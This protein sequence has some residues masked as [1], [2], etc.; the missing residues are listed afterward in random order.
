M[1]DCI[2]HHKNTLFLYEELVNI[3]GSTSRISETK[4]CANILF[5]NFPKGWV[6]ET[7]LAR[8]TEKFCLWSQLDFRVADDPSFSSSDF[9]QSKLLHIFTLSI[10]I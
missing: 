10:E 1:S 9:H 2:K 6:I 8:N 4:T 7:A 3:K 5:I